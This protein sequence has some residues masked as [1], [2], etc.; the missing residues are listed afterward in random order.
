MTTNE[1]REKIGDLIDESKGKTLKELNAIKHIGI[2]PETEIVIL[3]IKIGRLGDEA[4]KKL[5]RQLAK[6]IKIDFGFNGLKI[7]FEEDKKPIGNNAK[8]IIIASGKGGV[9]KSF[10]T[11]NIAYA[12]SRR[13][14]KVAIIDTDIYGASIPQILDMKITDPLVNDLGKIK[15]LRA[16]GMD[17]ISTDFFA[18]HEQ[19]VMWRG[20]MLKSMINSF[21]NQVSWDPFTDYVIIDTPA[22]TGDVMMDLKNIIPTAEVIIVTT[23]HEAASHVATKAAHG[24]IELHHDIIGIIENM[25]YLRNPESNTLEYPLG[26]GGGEEIAR[27]INSEVIA[28]IPIGLPTH[29]F[30]L[31]ELDEEAG[32]AYDD[33]ATLLLI[34]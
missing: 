18:E 2:D 3:I 5:R 11:A 7:Q 4:E 32:R 25:S 30:G 22:G 23:P 8:Y 17:I 16:Y 15:P 28:N 27:K 10:A 12:L 21:F 26:Q 19:P 34:R 33:I 24:F 20:A 1:I 31:Y 9:G 14:K 29:H 6:I 13:G